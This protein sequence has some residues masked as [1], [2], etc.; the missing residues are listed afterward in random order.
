M[1][2]VNDPIFFNLASTHGLSEGSPQGTKK[3]GIKS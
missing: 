1:S 2:E 3:E